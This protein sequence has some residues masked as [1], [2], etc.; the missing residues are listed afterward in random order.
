MDKINKVWT[1]YYKGTKMNAPKMIQVPSV[2][3]GNRPDF[4]EIKDALMK[5]GYSESDAF[6]LASSNLDW[7]FK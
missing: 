2:Y 5:M 1:G 6:Y 3:S 7:D 4:S